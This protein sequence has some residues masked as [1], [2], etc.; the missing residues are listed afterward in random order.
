M[1]R[2]QDRAIQSWQDRLLNDHLARME[3]PLEDDELPGTCKH[4][5][6]DTEST[7]ND[8]CENCYCEA[9]AAP[10]GGTECR[11]AKANSTK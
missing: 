11:K 3:T 6:G 8:V 7:E 10:E 5:G 2:N 1:N 9:D 4:C